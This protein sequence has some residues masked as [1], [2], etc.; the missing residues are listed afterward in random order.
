MS[1]FC[2]VI[3]TTRDAVE[4]VS[5]T[6]EIPDI[7]SVLCLKN[8][9][10]ALPVSPAYDAFI[11]RPTGIIQKLFGDKSYRTDL[12]APITQGQ[13]WQLGVAIG[14]LVHHHQALSATE[15][16]DPEKDLLIFAKVKLYLIGGVNKLCSS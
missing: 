16:A 1:R 13:S 5:I 7:A 15:D 11:R 3:P 8:S 12:S 4:L 10:Q 6:E 9:F 14:H 2:I